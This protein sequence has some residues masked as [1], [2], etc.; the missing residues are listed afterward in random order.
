MS[1]TPE[2]KGVS[3]VDFFC[4]GFGAIVG[5][6]WAVGFA[7]TVLYYLSGRWKRRG[8]LAE[9]GASAAPPLEKDPL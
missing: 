4:I 8:S 2:K 5:V 1:N 9:T 3:A 6:G 7:A